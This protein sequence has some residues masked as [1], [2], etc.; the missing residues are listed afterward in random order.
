MRVAAAQLPAQDDS[1]DKLFTTPNAVIM[2]DGASAFVP[3]TVPASTYADRLGRSIQQRLT[4]HPDATLTDVL[5][6]AIADTAEALDLTP[7]ESPSSTVAIA[8]VRDRLVD[9]LALGDTQIVTP[10]ETI[11]DDRMDRLELAPRRKYRE[12]LAA[13]TGYD[14]EHRAALRELPAEQAKHRNRNGGYWIAE[15]TR[16]AA[17]HAI[18]ATWPITDVP[19]VVLA[20]DGAYE[21]MEHLGLADW[22]SIAH[23]T[24]A[25]LDAILHRCHQWEEHD[26]PSATAM[27]RAKRHDDKAIAAVTLIA[28]E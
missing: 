26:D 10:R 4:E 17:Q 21:P 5:A 27:P 25:E 18:T 23:A 24:S 7:G 14:D 22:S 13:G 1:D 8:R 28:N 2:L 20:T 15:A 12:R 3:V 16:Q 11:R 19:W 9:V 6:D